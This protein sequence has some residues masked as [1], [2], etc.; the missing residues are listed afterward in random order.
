MRNFTIGQ[1]LTLAFLLMLTLT[2]LVAFIG[3]LQ[4]STL[5]STNDQI[6]TTELQRNLLA[7]RWASQIGTNWVR[8]SS[9]L[10]TNDP[11]YIKSL[12]KDMAATSEAITE[13]QKSLEAMVH[14]DTTQKLMAT[15]AETR[16]VYVAARAALLKKQ[17]NGD[18]ISDAV[19]HELRPL[20]Q[21]YLA[22]VGEVAKHAQNTLTKV[23]S[24]TTA[25]ASA[26]I[27]TIGMATGI[28]AILGFMFAIVVT[29]SIVKPLAHALDTA[30][31]ITSGNLASSITLTGKDEASRLLQALETMQI[32]LGRIVGHVRQ[33]AQEVALASQ[34]ISEGQQQLSDRTSMQSGALDETS[35]AIN[36]LG[37]AVS[38]NTDT[39]AQATKMSSEAMVVAKRC[40]D[41]MAAVVDTMT[42]INDSSR[43]IF[44]IIGVIDGIAFQTNILALNAAVEAARA[45]EQGRGFAV[46]ATEVRSLAGRSASA[47][48]EIKGLVGSSVER[49]DRGASLVNQAVVSMSDV[50]QSIERV[51]EFMSRMALASIEQSSGMNQTGEAIAQLDEASQQNAAMVEEMAAAASGLQTQSQALVEIVSMFDLGEHYTATTYKPPSRH[52]TEAHSDTGRIQGK[53]IPIG[54]KAKPNRPPFKSIE[55]KAALEM[56]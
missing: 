32:N 29:R 19:D 2:V 39:M 18:P 44:D 50:V 35:S 55:E 31:A 40:G 7:Q 28:A 1:R 37:A 11:A 5:R 51:S 25:L 46:V 47:A 3:I 10:K 23:Q 54:I 45:G 24:E 26:G 13:D 4:I 12:Q 38:Q 52:A 22:A 43:K 6:A 16:G 27:T 15:V 33:G 53:V 41:V 56:F 34:E 20:A 17:T 9:A 14:D 48:K 42:H 49:V 36:Q 8:A 21:T 30:H